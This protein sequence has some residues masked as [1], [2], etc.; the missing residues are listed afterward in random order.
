MT[1]VY[2]M[3]AVLQELMHSHTKNI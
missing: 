2:F 1:T 3:P